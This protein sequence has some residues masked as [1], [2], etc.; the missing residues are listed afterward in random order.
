MT[1]VFLCGKWYLY[2]SSRIT[3]RKISVLLWLKYEAKLLKKL[4][5]F[6]QEVL[7]RWENF[8]SYTSKSIMNTWKLTIMQYTIVVF[9]TKT[10]IILLIFLKNNVRS[11]AEKIWEQNQIWMTI[12]NFIGYMSTHSLVLGKKWN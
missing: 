3:K 2:F 8:L 11:E 10:L 7:T 1:T 12:E 5:K 6:Y 9:L 4:P